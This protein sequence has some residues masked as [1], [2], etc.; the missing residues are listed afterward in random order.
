MAQMVLVTVVVVGEL[1][2]GSDLIRYDRFKDA[3]ASF[4]ERHSLRLHSAVERLV[5][6]FQEPSV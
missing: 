6:I 2:N 5:H 1:H 3:F 4:L